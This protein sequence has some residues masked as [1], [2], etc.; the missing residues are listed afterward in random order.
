MHNLFL[1]ANPNPYR[2]G[3]SIPQACVQLVT[4]MV[5]LSVISTLLVTSIK[6]NKTIIGVEIQ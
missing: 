5:N 6:K 3:M 4:I 1:I 2:R